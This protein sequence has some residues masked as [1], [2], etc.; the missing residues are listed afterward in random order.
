M[1][2]FSRAPAVDSVGAIRIWANRQRTECQCHN[3]T[4]QKA[5]QEYRCKG[6]FPF[7][8]EPPLMLNLLILKYKKAPL[9]F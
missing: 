3:S 4:E 5:I 9:H 7:Y 8:V 1:V 6:S 2:Y